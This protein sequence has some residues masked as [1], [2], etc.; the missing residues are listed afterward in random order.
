MACRRPR[1]PRPHAK[2]YLLPK[3]AMI[4]RFNIGNKNA[5]SGA[6]FIVCV[7]SARTK[8]SRQLPEF[9]FACRPPQCPQPS[10]TRPS[11]QPA[12][13]TNFYNIILVFFCLTRQIRRRQRNSNHYRTGDDIFKTQQNI[14][15]YLH[16]LY[17]WACP[18]LPHWAIRYFFT[19]RILRMHPTLLQYE[20]A[21]CTLPYGLYVT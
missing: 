3:L 18:G 8:K 4:S 6:F 13:N 9:L 19:G 17:V 10:D 14:K 20:S 15:R 16:I 21:D 2:K 1:R 11:K 12:G 7:S 5:P